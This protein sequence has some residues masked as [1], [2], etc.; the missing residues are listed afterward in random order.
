MLIIDGNVLWWNS[1]NLIDCRTYWNYIT[2]K[3]M[4][5][6]WISNSCSARRSPHKR[7]SCFISLEI[8]ILCYVLLN[9]HIS[10]ASVGFLI[11]LPYPNLLLSWFNSSIINLLLNLRPFS[12][13]K[14]TI[15]SL[16]RCKVAPLG[17]FR[18]I[19]LFFNRQ[20][21]LLST[22]MRLIYQ[23]LLLYKE[24]ELTFLEFFLH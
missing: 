17:T 1:L 4:S 18:L 8:K 11:P 9:I 20:L 21:W 7:F 2:T 22:N 14:Y 16:S 15:C 10:G 3:I 5:F 24:G 12:S 6:S 19:R 13:T 23:W